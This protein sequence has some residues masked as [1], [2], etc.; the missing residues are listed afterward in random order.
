MVPAVSCWVYTWSPSISYFK[1]SINVSVSISPFAKYSENQAVQQVIQVIKERE[2]IQ[3]KV[4]IFHPIFFFCKIYMKRIVNLVSVQNIT[5][6]SSY[7][8][9]KIDI[10]SLLRPLTVIF[11]HVHS[12][13]NYYIYHKAQTM[14]KRILEVYMYIY[15]FKNNI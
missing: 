12:H 2:G 13:L 1:L 15:V 14:C 5:F 6:K 4:D 7:N 3:K 9:F 10:Q 11:S 8:W